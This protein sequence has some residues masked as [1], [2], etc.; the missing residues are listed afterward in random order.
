MAAKMKIAPFSSRAPFPLIPAFSLREKVKLDD[1]L[2]NS[3]ASDSIQ[4]KEVRG[5]SARSLL[6]AQIG[7]HRLVPEIQRAVQFFNPRQNTRF[8]DIG[9]NCWVVPLTGVVHVLDY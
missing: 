2:V 8:E 4:R 1:A 7:E 3:N 5:F 9:E 6:P